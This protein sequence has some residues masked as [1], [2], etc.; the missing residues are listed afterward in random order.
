[1]QEPNLKSAIVLGWRQT[2]F[3]KYIAKSLNTETL[4]FNFT[5]KH[6]NQKSMIDRS[7]KKLLNHK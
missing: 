5:K 7:I 4:G 1:M 6:K 3:T 2:Y